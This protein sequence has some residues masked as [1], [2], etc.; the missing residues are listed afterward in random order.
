MSENEQ[1]ND[2]LKE[3]EPLSL[4]LLDDHVQRLIHSAKN[5]FNE[6]VRLI[7][8]ITL[9]GADHQSSLNFRARFFEVM[10]EALAKGDDLVIEVQTYAL[11]ISDQVIYEDSKV[12]GNFIYRFYTDGIRELRF[13][14][15]I[16]SEEVDQLLNIF[17]LD[18]TAPS[19]FEDDAV[20]MMWS[21]KFEH[22]TYAVATQYNE[23]TQ[24]ADE[25]LFNF[26]DELNRLS[27]YCH[28]AQSY[29]RPAPIKLS[30]AAEQSQNLEHLKKMNKRELLE[31]L[32]SLSHETQSQRLQVAGQDRFVQLLDKL[33]QLFA[34]EAEVGD[35]E[36]L[37]RQA[38]FIAT[39]KQLEQL[40]SCWAVPVFMQQVM[41]PLKSSDHPQAI[42][43]LACVKLLGSAATPHIARALGEVAEAHIEVLNQLILPFIEQHPIELC[44]VVRT[45]DFLHNKRLIPL[46]YSS[47]SDELCLQVFQT[48][49]KHQDQGVRY[50]VLLSLPERLYN[51]HILTK[52]LIEGLQDSYSKIRTLSSFRLSKL[53]DSESRATLKQY[54]DA[55]VKDLA[56]I[57]LRKL[58]AALALMGEA[59]A[60]FAEYW[61]QHSSGIS[62]SAFSGKGRDEGHCALIALALS[63]Q[64]TEYR[65]VLE[66]AT[67]RKLGG[68]SF[69]E[70][71]QWGLAYLESNQG[72]QD[73]MIYELFFRNQL[74]LPK[75]RQR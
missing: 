59:S 9:Y 65:A 38:M 46:L 58:F 15:G 3:F 34:Q 49:W 45:A 11:V 47:Q 17:L 21:Q 48:G 7:K 13:K 37:M 25:Y 51:S 61:S 60:Y 2:L 27:D 44:R 42:S 4:E 67:N 20:T 72:A 64:A 39:P 6:L 56:L 31:K 19:L 62:F 66:K 5:V 57:D 10:T 36:R 40:V 22:I 8:S 55:G 43:A 70:A 71:A 12:E 26:T 35:L 41:F 24:E 16:R 23:D 74:S 14:Q 75:G 30:L 32:I 63:S 52:A 53:K 73:Q 18:W 68:A 28:T 29:V 1:A 33:A 50:E 69:I 54:L